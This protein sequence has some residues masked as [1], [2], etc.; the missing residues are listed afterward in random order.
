M[1]LEAVGSTYCAQK[2]YETYGGVELFVLPGEP[3]G[4]TPAK[5]SNGDEN[6]QNTSSTTTKATINVIILDKSGKLLGKAP[7]TLF[8]IY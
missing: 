6:P 4:H 1:G 5:R 7:G 8:P 3:Y 2:R